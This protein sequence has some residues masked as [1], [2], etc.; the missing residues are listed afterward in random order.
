MDEVVGYKHIP[1]LIAPDKGTRGTPKRW[2]TIGRASWMRTV[3]RADYGHQRYRK[4]KQTVEPCSATPNTTAAST[5]S[6]DAAGPRCAW[7]GDY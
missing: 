1:V 3:L 4:R 6:T 5:A 2:L 7:S